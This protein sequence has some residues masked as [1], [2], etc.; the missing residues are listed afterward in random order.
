MSDFPGPGSCLFD[1]MGAVNSAH[2]WSVRAKLLSVFCL[3]TGAQML[4]N[5]NVFPVNTEPVP[6]DT[7]THTHIFIQ[8]YK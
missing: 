1:V 2:V 7:H 3:G 4:V 8:I 6:P 5:N